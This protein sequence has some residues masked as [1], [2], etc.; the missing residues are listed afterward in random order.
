MRE[1]KTGVESDRGGAFKEYLIE[2]VIFEP[3][4]EGGEGASH[5]DI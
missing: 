5:V 4:L 2:E 3:R 1:S